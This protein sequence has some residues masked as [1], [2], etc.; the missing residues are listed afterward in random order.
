ML[1]VGT[2]LVFLS[3]YRTCTHM[4]VVLTIV[5]VCLPTTTKPEATYS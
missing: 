4:K 3:R 1:A 5:V 2:G